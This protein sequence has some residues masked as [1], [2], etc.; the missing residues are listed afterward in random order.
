MEAVEQR[1][2]RADARA[3]SYAQA[4]AFITI[5]LSTFDVCCVGLFGPLVLMAVECVMLRLRGHPCNQGRI[6]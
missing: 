1:G 6:V 4:C 2:R 3:W 5:R